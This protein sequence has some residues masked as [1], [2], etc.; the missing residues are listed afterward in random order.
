MGLLYSDFLPYGKSKPTVHDRQATLIKFF[1][2]VHRLKLINL[3]ASFTL[4]KFHKDTEWMAG[5]YEP[6]EK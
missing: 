3:S 6:E 5:K 4:I 1:L 2:V